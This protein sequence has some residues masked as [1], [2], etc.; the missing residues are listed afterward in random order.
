MSEYD[1]F[2]ASATVRQQHMPAF[3]VEPHLVE[4]DVAGS[5]DGRVSFRS[6][7]TQLREA[8]E[9]TWVVHG[10]AGSGK[11]TALRGLEIE[12][13]RSGTPVLFLRSA[14]LR[15]ATIAKGMDVPEFVQRARPAGIPEKLWKSRVKHRKV[16]VLLDGVNEMR[17]EFPS[18]RTWR[19]IG[20]LVAGNHGFTVV[21]SSRNP[22]ESVGEFRWVRRLRLQEFSTEQ[23]REYL[24]N[25]G[26]DANAHLEWLERIGLSPLSTN[27][28][29]L[30]GLVTLMSRRDPRDNP[31]P[32]S[33]ADLVRA[34]AHAHMLPDGVPPAVTRHV[35]S[36][37]TVDAAWAACAA[38][39]HFA[40]S[41]GFTRQD[42]LRLL[43][44]SLPPEPYGDIL[45]FFLDTGPVEPGVG[46]TP[47][48]ARSFALSHQRY[49][50]CGLA[51]G[52]GREIPPPITYA[53]HFFGGFVAD[54]SALQT[55]PVS[56]TVEVI[57]IAV[58]EARFD[59]LCDILVANAPLM[60]PGTRM[61]VWQALG[62]GFTM[63]RTHRTRLADA[64]GSLPRVSL[65]EGLASGL[66][67]GLAAERPDVWSHVR[68]ALIMGTLDGRQLQKLMRQAER[69]RSV[70]RTRASLAE[71]APPS[72]HEQRSREATAY[73]TP[74]TRSPPH[75][76]AGRGRFPSRRPT[77]RMPTPRTEKIPLSASSP[78]IA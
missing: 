66:L 8:G 30:R 2:A 58:A 31:D 10:S 38:R 54:W 48:A 13:L 46:K 70:E 56:A 50:E 61:E 41:G 45:D 23:V 77:P 67:D 35:E 76:E 4:Q 51:V 40:E 53:G 27:P 12:L 64:V 49:A 28:L 25:H 78:R 16:V 11:T 74:A 47:V 73:P 1:A 22:D 59:T 44:K 63:S 24:A 62:R 39:G 14:L 32:G 15:Q 68:D 34:A 3:W 5:G 21:I 17:R 26:L 37:A 52:W 75:I 9:V 60:D 42:A 29:L 65:L 69:R 72:P 71:L 7:A 57:G 20:Q 18:G 55:D 19:L 6:F 33:R 36:G 43:T